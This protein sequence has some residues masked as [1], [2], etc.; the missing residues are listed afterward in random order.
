MFDI[1]KMY[2]EA[3]NGEII[4]ASQCLALIERYK[5]IIIWGAGNLGYAVGQELLKRG[6]RISTYWDIR[7]DR[8]NTYLGLPVKEPLQGEREGTLVVFCITNAFIM[9][10]LLEDLK[11]KQ[12]E[13][14]DGRYVYQ[15]FCCPVSVSSP[16]IKECYQRKECN[17]ATCKRMSNTMYRANENRDKIFINTLD[18]YVTQKC[19]LGC[20]YCYIY[21]NSYPKEKKVNFDTQRILKDIDII[22]EAASFIK[23]MVPFGGEP[24][25]HP[26]IGLIVEKMASKE[27]VGLID[28][29][30]NGIFS[31]PDSELKK[32]K[33]ANVKINISN[34]TTTLDEKLIAIYQKNIARMQE[35]GLNVVVHNET[36]QWRK[37]GDLTENNLEISGLRK[38]KEV[39]GN[40]CNAGTLEKDTTETMIIKDGK[41]FA[42]QHCDTVYNLGIVPENTDYIVLSEELSGSEIAANMKELLRKDYYEACKYCNP[43]IELV[44]YAGEQGIDERYIIVPKD[45]EI[46]NGY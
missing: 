38:K 16:R 35:M 22:C 6:V 40:F 36:P 34:Y 2:K 45:K 3:E 42:C 11:E 5:N 23:R 37:P 41:F 29:I 25:L 44:E 28:I 20:K 46:K 19:S 1:E 32:L 39:C 43:S 10:K 12:F 8:I 18:V 14:I 30:S 13:F 24:F 9:P 27:N 31:Q 4:N 7:Y 33:H 21:T 15:A 26:D 17:L